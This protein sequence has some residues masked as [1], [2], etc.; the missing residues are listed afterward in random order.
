MYVRCYSMTSLLYIV[1]WESGVVVQSIFKRS[2]R[3]E[4][5]QSKR[6]AAAH[7]R[8]LTTLPARV[9]RLNTFY[10]AQIYQL[11]YIQAIVNTL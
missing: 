5:I 6:T 2:N 1:F 10:I 11:R 7:Q 9:S 3:L 4:L 8:Q